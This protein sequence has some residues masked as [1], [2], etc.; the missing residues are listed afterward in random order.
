MSAPAAA[1]LEALK[2]AAHGSWEPRRVLTLESARKRTAFVRGLRIVF[3]IAALALTTTVFVQLL[4]TALQPDDA[5]EEVV[6]TDV[7]MINP[8]FTGR[9]ENLTPYL[10]TADSAVRRRDS[11]VGLTDLER[12][13]LNYNFLAETEEA[14][15]V[16][17]ETGV[18]DPTN[19]ILQL[20]TDVN[21]ATDTGYSFETTTAQIHLR[22]E[23]VVG[24][25]PVDGTGPV[26]RIRSDRFEIR[27]GGDHVIFEG[28]VRARIVQDRTRPDALE[29]EN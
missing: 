11:D 22:D 28:R 21:F 1:G 9:D 6:G 19:R 16:L 10:L 26:G 2:P 23:R 29:G 5:P 12:P 13:R 25:E 17:A 18:F 15:S 8:R 27:D 14:T 4:M 3:T 24:E 20:D 7:R